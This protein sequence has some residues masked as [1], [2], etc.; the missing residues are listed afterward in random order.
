M[1]DYKQIVGSIKYEFSCGCL[2]EMQLTCT[3]YNTCDIPE[4]GVDDVRVIEV[5][6]EHSDLRD[7]IPDEVIDQM[8]EVTPFDADDLEEMM[9]HDDTIIMEEPVNMVARD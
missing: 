4:V 7:E 1:L 8:L 3:T 2:L 5:C 9:R 6:D